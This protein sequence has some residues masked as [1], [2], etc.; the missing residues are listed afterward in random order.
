MYSSRIEDISMQII[1]QAVL[2]AYCLPIMAVYV[3]ITA[4]QRLKA[5]IVSVEQSVGVRVLSMVRFSPHF[6]VQQ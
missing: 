4:G 6:P 1:M 3:L 2:L 5:S